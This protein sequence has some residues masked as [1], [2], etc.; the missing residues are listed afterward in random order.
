MVITSL[1]NIKKDLSEVGH[2]SVK[3]E[4]NSF[5][6]MLR[7]FFFFVSYQMLYRKPTIV[8]LVVSTMLYPFIKIQNCIVQKIISYNKSWQDNQFLQKKISLLEQENY[9]LLAENISLHASGH[10]LENIQEL[11]AF[12]KRYDFQKAMLAQV[13]F[14]Q[15]SSTQQMLIV[16]CGSL[17]GSEVDMVAV[18]KSCLIGRVEFVYP[19]YSKI[20]LIT[21]SCCKVAA[22]CRSSK[23]RGIHEGCNKQ[24]SSLQFVSHLSKLTADDILIS[25]GEGLIF[26]QGFGI[27]RIDSFELD[28]LYYKIVI[29][30]LLKLEE[31]EYCYLIKKGQESC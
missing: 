18:Y 17:H 9:S 15:C 13:I 2:G 6:S 10:F 28:G 4:D 12:K 24:E 19:Y 22:Y 29:K 26:P 14:K 23:A 30:P 8:E 16:D 11:I 1:H 5:N 20:R 7:G 3:N 25:S 27:G 21:D 31:L